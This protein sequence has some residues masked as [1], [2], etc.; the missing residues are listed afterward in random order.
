MRQTGIPPLRTMLASFLPGA[1]THCQ[2]NQRLPKHAEGHE[3][4]GQKLGGG[5]GATS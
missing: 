2:T 1:R 3:A 4:Q 5:G